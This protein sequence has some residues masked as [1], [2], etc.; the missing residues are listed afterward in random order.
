MDEDEVLA[1][2]LSHDARVGLVLLDVLPERHPHIVKDF[3]RAGEVDSGE[4]R[5][6]H[7]RASDF[8]ARARDEV[9]DSVGKPRFLEELHQVIAG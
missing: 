7:H 5:L 9:D 1:S 8:S 6:I 4:A 3:R 2:G